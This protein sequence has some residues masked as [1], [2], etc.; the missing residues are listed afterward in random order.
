MSEITISNSNRNIALNSDE[1]YD[2]KQ[3][4]QWLRRKAGDPTIR[5][6][7]PDTS[8]DTERQLAV[9]QKILGV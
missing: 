8:Q 4:E 3:L 6:F 2:L 9:I 7:N 1:Q 5:A